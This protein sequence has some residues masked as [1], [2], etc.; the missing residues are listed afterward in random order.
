MSAEIARL[1]EE[2]AQLEKRIKTRAGRVR[3]PKSEKDEKNRLEAEL[4]Q[5]EQTRKEAEQRADK[6]SLS[7]PGWHWSRR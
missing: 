6:D 7:S 2:K 4:K 5:L 3:V 1:S